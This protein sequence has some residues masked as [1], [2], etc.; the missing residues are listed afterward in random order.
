MTTQAGS[1]SAAGGDDLRQKGSKKEQLENEWLMV[2][3]DSSS[4]MGAGAK[5]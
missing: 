4:D 3:Y 5:V 1:F 2:R